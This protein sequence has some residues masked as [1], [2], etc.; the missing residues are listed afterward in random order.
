[1][2]SFFTCSSM[3]LAPFLAGATGAGAMHVGW[4]LYSRRGLDTLRIK[5]S[6]LWKALDAY[7]AHKH[8]KDK[9]NGFVYEFLCIYGLQM[10]KIIYE[11][12]TKANADEKHIFDQKMGEAIEEMVSMIPKTTKA[13]F[14]PLAAG[15][16][17]AGAVG[18]AVRHSMVG[19]A[20]LEQDV[21]NLCK[22]LKVETMLDADKSIVQLLLTVFGKNKIDPLVM[23][24]IEPSNIYTM[25]RL[26]QKPV[27]HV[28][29]R[30]TIREKIKI[31][32]AVDA[33]NKT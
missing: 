11:P 32:A 3:S 5:Y 13:V 4:H 25:I 14:L 29:A 19:D 6:D 9:R 8:D 15:T 27:I 17:S 18:F 31:Q 10:F 1:M 16:L 22:L 7:L 2:C 12:W 30:I 23:E 21:A 33:K 24:K 26:F 20:A 28:H